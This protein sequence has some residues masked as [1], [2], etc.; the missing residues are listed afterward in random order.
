M[1][2]S[3]AK[4]PVF[5]KENPGSLR[6]R[7]EIPAPNCTAP[8]NS[9]NA[10]TARRAARGRATRA[11]IANA[12]AVAPTYTGRW[13][14]KM[15]LPSSTALVGRPVVGE[16]R[17]QEIRGLRG[18]VEARPEVHVAGVQRELRE[19][20]QHE[21]GEAASREQPG[22]EQPD[23][24]SAGALGRAD[25]FAAIRHTKN[26]NVAKSAMKLDSG[27]PPRS[28]S[29]TSRPSAATRSRSGRRTTRSVATSNHGMKAQTLV[30]GQVSST[31]K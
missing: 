22:A 16:E 18:R 27:C 7:S 28:D 26:A 9:P 5:T 2:T 4:Y 23:R 10:A 12:S 20:N 1:A 6:M 29:A 24:P 11:I 31:T 17:S 25:S 21:G 30:C 14:A 15:T 13:A 3:T 8:Q 19:G